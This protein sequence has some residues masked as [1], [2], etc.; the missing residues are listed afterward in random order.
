M[1]ERKLRIDHEGHLSIYH[2]VPLHTHPPMHPDARD[3]VQH[4]S[5]VKEESKPQSEKPEQGFI[6]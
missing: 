6:N 4:C 5:V 3:L 1:K 2:H